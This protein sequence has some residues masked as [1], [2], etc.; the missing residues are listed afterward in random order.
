MND[1]ARPWRGRGDRRRASHADLLPYHRAAC[2]PPALITVTIVS[3]RFVWDDFLGPL[4]SF[5]DASTYTVPLGLRLF[6]G[7]YNSRSQLVM[8]TSVV[9]VAP[10]IVVF[11]VARRFCVAGMTL[12]GIKG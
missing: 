2:S 9:V 4:L 1:T 11:F 8:A 6:M 12:T 3:G 7:L 5:T 10:V